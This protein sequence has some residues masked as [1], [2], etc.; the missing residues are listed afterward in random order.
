MTPDFSCPPYLEHS[1]S[2]VST[3]QS[4]ETSSGKHW[5]GGIGPISAGLWVSGVARA[6]PG[7]RLAHPEGQN[8]EE[9]KTVWGKIDRNLR[10][11]WGKWNSCPPGT[12]RLATALLW[13]VQPRR[14]QYPI[15]TKYYFKMCENFINSSSIGHRPISWSSNSEPRQ[16][17]PA[18]KHFV[19]SSLF[20]PAK[21]SN[22]VA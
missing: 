6:F 8:E 17:I 16:A 12:V 7:G 18:S 5:Q 15:S 3:C 4:W 11:K 13:V 20:W 22:S 14:P 1:G 19:Y 10:K 9:N 2:L 21:Q